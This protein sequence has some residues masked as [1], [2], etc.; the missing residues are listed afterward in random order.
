MSKKN[1]NSPDV[2]KG[3][4]NA[5]PADGQEAI[6]QA[7]ADLRKELLDKGEA[8][9]VEIKTQVDHLRAEIK[10]AN[11]NANARIEALST[12]FVEMEAAVSDQSDRIVALERDLKKVLDELATH[13]TRLEDGEARSRRFNLRVSG[14]LE[15]RET[16]KRPTEFVSQCLKDA[17]GLSKL[18]TLDIA[19]RTLRA[20][21]DEEDGRPP[22]AFVVRC[23]YFQEREEIL[24]KA[25]QAKKA[26][27]A[28]GDV[29]HVHQDFTH[30]VAQQ[31]AKFNEVRGLLR[32]CDG[33]RYGLWYPA[34]LKITTSDGRCTS[35]KDPI[36]ARD[37][38][39]KNLKPKK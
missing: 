24:K 3:Q 1:K 5:T 26:T 9:S 8:Q 32:S 36:K 25:R 6:L 33:V 13:K 14:I 21:S 37:F 12:Q 34:E 10:Q 22:R 27:T 4:A 38:I 31:R 11:D 20:R 16:G 2:A 7:I 15:G 39:Q 23:H 30:A 17:Y 28:D 29:V 35:F 18:P 19:H